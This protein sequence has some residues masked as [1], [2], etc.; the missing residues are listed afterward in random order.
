[1]ISSKSSFSRCKKTSSLNSAA[2]NAPKLAR[3][4]QTNFRKDSVAKMSGG[5]PFWQEFDFRNVLILDVALNWKH[6][7]GVAVREFVKEV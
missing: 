5:S 3:D 1:M 4:K 7:T 6:G 2:S